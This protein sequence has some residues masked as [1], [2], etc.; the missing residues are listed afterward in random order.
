MA[1][2][3]H[4][5][6]RD[7]IRYH[8]RT[9]DGKR[10]SIDK[11]IPNNLSKSELID[12]WAT[13][14][15]EAKDRVRSLKSL[16]NVLFENVVDIVLQ[17]HESRGKLRGAGEI[18][19]FERIQSELSGP[20]N[21][22]FTIRYNKFVDRLANDG[23]RKGKTTY[24]YSQNTIS[25]FEQCIRTVINTAYRRGLI[26]EIPVCCRERGRAL[27]FRDRYLSADEWT[28]LENALAG[29]YL[30]W[31]V[32]FMSTFPCRKSDCFRLRTGNLF[33]FG[34][35]GP[36]IE[37]AAEKTGL[38]TVFPLEQFQELLDYLLGLPAGL[39]FTQPN[40]S[41][42]IDPRHEWERILAT[43]K[44]S[45]LHLHDLK[46][47]ATGDRLADGFTVDRMIR[48]GW[49]ASPAMILRVYNR[50][51]AVDVMRQMRAEAGRGY[52]EVGKQA[53]S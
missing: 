12:S 35:N 48:L 17:D 51:R 8:Y 45:D 13:L 29:S 5:A 23:Y 19:R 1:T 33:L 24:R 40:G 36:Y 25:H 7:L 21:E 30:E 41:P 26:R 15:A 14:K 27:K 43:A 2:I 39:L 6:R 52:V 53:N 22:G 44:I 16:D 50:V 9:P 3:P 32:R 38:L 10:R 31:P 47:K 46:A 49:Y 4:D 34:S 18:E 37:M 42:I 20:I 11:L 28:R